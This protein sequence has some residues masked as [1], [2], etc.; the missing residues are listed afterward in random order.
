MVVGR[1]KAYAVIIITFLLAFI[2]MVLPMPSWSAWL[3]PNWLLLVLIFWGIALPQRVGILVAWMMG[4]VLDILLGSM[5]GEHALSFVCVQYLVVHFRP[6]LKQYGVI[7]LMLSVL[8]LLYLDHL[9][10]YAIQGIIHQ[11]PVRLTYWLQPL[12]SV[13]LWPWL[14]IL[15][16]FFRWR[17]QVHYH[18]EL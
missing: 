2:L 5:L 18:T 1:S 16:K 4:L 6:Q 14:D 11:Y 17:F 13:L 8:F 15:L 12:I 9:I 10:L 7:Q 3:R